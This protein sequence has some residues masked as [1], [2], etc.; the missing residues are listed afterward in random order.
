MTDLTKRIIYLTTAG[1][2]AVV[3]PIE[4][5]LTLAE[6]AARSV[7]TGL[8]YKFLDAADLPTDRS[9]RDRWTIDAAELTDGVGAAPVEG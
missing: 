4:C 2:L 3:T 9:E 7:P 6:I 8:P 5:G 1:A